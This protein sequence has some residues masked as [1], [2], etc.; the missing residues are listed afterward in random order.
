M[1]ELFKELAYS[2]TPMGELI[3]RRRREL[4]LNVDVYEIK[5]N[6]E[7]LMSSLFTAAE[8]EL[9]RMGLEALDAEKADVVVGGLGLGYTAQAAL[10]DERVSSLT[11]IDNIAEVIEWHREKLVPLGEVLTKDSRCRLVQGDFF[12][13]AAGDGFD[14]NEPG[15]CFHAILLDIDHS[16]AL[17]LHP[18]HDGFY[19][20]AGLVRLAAYLHPGGVFAMWSND[21]PEESFSTALA[22]VFAYSDARIV[23]FP[24]HLQNR[25]ATA[26]I[27]L[28][29]KAA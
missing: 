15:R 26:T 1:S 12:A 29:G 5:L 8:I 6:G 20:V 2:L 17:T 21:P 19:T 3:L 4:S 27:Y 14:E 25:D 16:P 23:R 13:M 7:F 22:E 10:E 11:V 18:S 28:A 24:N 9:A